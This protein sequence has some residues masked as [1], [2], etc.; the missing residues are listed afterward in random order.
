M[1]YL[2]YPRVSLCRV[3]NPPVS[4]RGL[5][6][7]FVPDAWPGAVSAVGTLDRAATRAR[8]R[9]RERRSRAPSVMSHKADD[10]SHARM[11]Y[12]MCSI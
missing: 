5:V 2:I 4:G 10:I 9:W 12:W 3:G 6:G 1:L 7:W 11:N 8:A